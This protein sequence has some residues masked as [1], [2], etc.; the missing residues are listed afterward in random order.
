MSLKPSR[1]LALAAR[2]GVNVLDPDGNSPAAAIA[3]A[4]TATPD[5]DPN[6]PDM[7]DAAATAAHTA[8]A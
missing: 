6:T 7:F 2:Y 3:T 4:T 1:R 8:T 5:R